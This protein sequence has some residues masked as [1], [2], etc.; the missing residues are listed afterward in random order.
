MPLYDYRCEGCGSFRAFRPMAESTRDTPC[1]R[2]SVPAARQLAAP[3]LGG[4]PPGWLGEG[5]TGS[6]GS[7]GS[8]G[9]RMGTGGGWR[10]SCGFGCGHPGCG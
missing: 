4:R 1:P 3:M 10:R 6:S 5:A 2:C 9:S 7:A 8:A